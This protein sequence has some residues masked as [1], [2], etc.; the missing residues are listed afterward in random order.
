MKSYGKL[1]DH[2]MQED[3]III[4]IKNSSKGKRSRKDVKKVYG[5]PSEQV[6]WVSLYALNFKNAEHEPIEIY[7]G[8]SRKKRQII[9]PKYKEQIIHHMIANVLIPI[10][11]SSM[12]HHTY[13]S[14]PGKGAHNAKKAVEKWI[15][16]DK[17]NVKYCLK[18]D[19]KKFFNSI[20]HDILKDK[21][22]KLIRDK[23]FLKLLFEVIDVQPKGLPLG[24][25]TSQWLAN[26]YLTALDHYIK[27][28]LRAK[29]YVRYMDDM[30]VFGSKK[31]DLHRIRQGIS[32]YLEDK[33]GLRLKENWQVFRFDYKKHG[34]RR[35]RALDF[36]GFKFYR[37]KT[38]LRKSIMYKMT[39]KARKIGKKEKATLYDCRQMLSYLGWIDCTD[40]YNMYKKWV[41]PYVKFGQLKKHISKVDHL[42]KINQE[43]DDYDSEFWQVPVYADALAA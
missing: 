17:K 26:W 10:F 2:L 11:M 36:M 25:Y 1:W 38:T 14:I 6:G 37:D 41:K 29:H 31:R 35:G 33:L 30:V 3:N 18:M 24:F 27:E 20:P 13:G 19:I 39:R 34:K 42:L 28:E 22:R 8:I 23:K 40:T 12:Y 32:D 16:H 43:V 4:A 9:V 7:D 5:K 15:K 21:L